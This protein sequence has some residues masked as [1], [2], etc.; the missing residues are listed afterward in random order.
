[1][2][3]RLKPR[4][5]LSIRSP[6]LSSLP[7]YVTHSFQLPCPDLILKVLSTVWSI[8]VIQNFFIYMN[9][10]SECE[11]T[12]IYIYDLREVEQTKIKRLLLSLPL[13]GFCGFEELKL[14]RWNKNLVNSLSTSSKSIENWKFHLN[15]PNQIDF[16]SPLSIA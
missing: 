10:H 2:H 1:M 4:E 3:V 8:L 16:L 14:K 7:D 9:Y 6:S 15:I 5:S 11:I 12:F 13:F